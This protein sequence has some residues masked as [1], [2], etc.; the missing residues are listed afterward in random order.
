M[1]KTV[2]ETPEQKMER[3]IALTVAGLPARPAPVTLEGRVLAAIAEGNPHF[4]RAQGFAAWPSPVRWLALPALTIFAAALLIALGGAGRDTAGL[5]RA[6]VPVGWTAL[7]DALRATM[8]AAGG[9]MAQLWRSV[10]GSWWYVALAVFV[11][12]YASVV[13][14]GLT[15][16]RLLRTRK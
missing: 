8:E 6:F 4:A 16:Y 14:L 11:C 3:L 9:A 5:V 7:W 1:N 15:A 13:G 10:P 12:W 2:H